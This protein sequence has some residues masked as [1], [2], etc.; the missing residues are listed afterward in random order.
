MSAATDSALSEAAWSTAT[1]FADLQS[2]MLRFLRGDLC[3]TPTYDGHLDTE[4]ASIR[5]QLIAITERGFTTTMSQPGLND[6]EGL[7]QR[8]FIIGVGDPIANGRL[9]RMARAEGRFVSQPSGQGA[10]VASR[11]VTG[12]EMRT[13]AVMPLES[14]SLSDAFLG[15][16]HLLAGL[17]PLAIM[18]LTYGGDRIFQQAIR[19]LEGGY[20]D[21]SEVS[22]S[23]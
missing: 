14:P 10:L 4:S 3:S 11:E 5:S 7:Q 6:P 15:F 9:L 18:D 8:A 16:E 12:D 20:D 22:V 17:Q 23:A 1:S 2:L 19:A 13:L 21:R